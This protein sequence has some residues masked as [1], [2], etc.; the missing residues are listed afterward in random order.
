MATVRP[1]PELRDV[2]QGSLIDP[3]ILLALDQA[4]T[5]GA[6]RR[7]AARNPDQ[8]LSWNALAEAGRLKA[9]AHLRAWAVT[10]AEPIGRSRG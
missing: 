8:A 3:D 9:M 10:R 1:P 2:G 5:A 4:I 6:C 7:A